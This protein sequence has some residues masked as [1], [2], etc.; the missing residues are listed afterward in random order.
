MRP[1]GLIASAALASRT[2]VAGNP[3]RLAR[4]DTATQIDALCM[5]QAA[6]FRKGN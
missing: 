6:R 3:W 2:D 4:M 5:R 1:C